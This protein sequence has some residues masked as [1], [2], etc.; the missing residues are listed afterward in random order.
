MSV[1][2]NSFNDQYGALTIFYDQIPE[3]AKEA[4]Q[5]EMYLN[6]LFR[7][8]QYLYRKTA[9][10]PDCEGMMDDLNNSM[11]SVT[12]SIV[13]PPSNHMVC[14]YYMDAADLNDT[15]IDQFYKRANDLKK[16]L[17][18]QNLMD[19]HHVIVFRHQ[20]ASLDDSQ[21]EQLFHCLKR[22]MMED[23]YISKEIYML[24]KNVLGK[25]ELQE[26]GIVQL[27]FL[28]TR[29]IN[30]YIVNAV[31]VSGNC[32][33]MVTYD[34]FYANKAKTCQAA[35]DEI[36]KWLTVEADPGFNRMKD[37]VNNIISEGTADRRVKK[38]GLRG[39][40][41]LYPVRVTEFYKSGFLGLGGY[42]C[43]IGPGHPL[44]K[45]QI[46][47][48]AQNMD[49]KI[50]EEAK[51]GE[52]EKLIKEEYRYQDH[53]A[54]KT[55]IEEEA[56]FGLLLEGTQ[57]SASN[58]A[59]EE[60]FIK[61]MTEH[62]V[63]VISELQGGENLEEQKLHMEKK[64]VQRMREMNKASRYDTLN[65]CFN[66]IDEKTNLEVINGEFGSKEFTH[67]ML[68]GAAVE[69]VKSQGKEIRGI[70]M[71]DIYANINPNEIE[72][73]K[74]YTICDLSKE[75]AEENLARIID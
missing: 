57:A 26:R 43:D 48:F 55:L 65:D 39:K 34:D 53:K 29:S 36:D 74:M 11:D 59:E 75:N 54:L 44:I 52:L 62:L 40:T 23:V 24:R 13:M 70:N 64:R 58:N 68:A 28:L 38:R 32:L 15:W 45:E 42:K 4:S 67:V 16:M 10:I 17:P 6:D 72:V 69:A 50:L 37:Y 30:N 7:S 33:R 2:T 3:S 1:N 18:I 21:K 14:C 25:Y 20:I 22:L 9:E 27:L 61:L 46:A 12:D 63:Q 47:E 49:K 5:M 73:T 71:A 51:I 41:S 66:L 60:E 19:Q 8:E 56:L 31:N 35:I